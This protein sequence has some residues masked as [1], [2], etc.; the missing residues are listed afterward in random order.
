MRGEWEGVGGRCAPNWKKAKD[1]KDFVCV[2]KANKA[3][4][5]DTKCA[6]SLSSKISMKMD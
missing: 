6:L 1:I 5:M 2:T 4:P 3:Y